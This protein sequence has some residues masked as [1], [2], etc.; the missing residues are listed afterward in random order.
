[1]TQTE[2]M[3]DPRHFY[4]E[5]KNDPHDILRAQCLFLVTLKEYPYPFESPFI[6]AR[7]HMINPF[8]TT[9]TDFNH[10]CFYFD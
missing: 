7:M 6:Q 8:S 3:I 9:G 5:A 4:V 2:A 1:M 10:M